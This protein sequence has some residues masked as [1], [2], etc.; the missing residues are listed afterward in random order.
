MSFLIS[1]LSLETEMYT[2]KRLVTDYVI[3]Y[4][5]LANRNRDSP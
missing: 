5:F 3:D 4:L 1:I 2:R